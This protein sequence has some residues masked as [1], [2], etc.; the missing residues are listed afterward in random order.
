VWYD[1][2]STT[3]G[4]LEKEVP[5]DPEFDVQGYVLDAIRSGDF[6][7]YA[8]EEGR[9]RINFL[10]NNDITGGNS[11]SPVLNAQAELVGLAFDGN[12]ESLSGDILFNPAMNRTISV[13]ILYVLYVI[14]KVMKAPWIIDELK[15]VE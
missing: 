1:S 8:D 5:G 15:L 7:R 3:N 13:D 10:S 2:F 12:W 9:M 11:G 14:D 6:G 4:V